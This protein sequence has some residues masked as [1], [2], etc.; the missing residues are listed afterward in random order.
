MKVGKN[1]E[2]EYILDDDINQDMDVREHD[3]PIDIN[4]AYKDN[5]ENQNRT[6]PTSSEKYVTI[7]NPSSSSTRKK[8]DVLIKKLCDDKNGYVPPMGAAASERHDDISNVYKS[9]TEAK[10][11][12]T[13]SEEPYEEPVAEVDNNEA[14]D[15][16]Y[17]TTMLHMKPAT[18]SSNRSPNSDSACFDLDTSNL[19]ITS[20]TT[21]KNIDHVYASLPQVTRGLQNQQMKNCIPQTHHKSHRDTRS[22]SSH[23]HD[24]TQTR[25]W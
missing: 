24:K 6:F 5:D 15:G 16:D 21:T 7:K 12:S 19:E 25:S 14:H 11:K 1:D 13:M 4:D 20:P 8:C 2:E 9:D 18:S 23:G 10:N 22:S 3:K 17:T